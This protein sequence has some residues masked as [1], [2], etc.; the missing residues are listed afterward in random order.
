MNIY[1]FRDFLQVTAKTSICILHIA[2]RIRRDKETLFFFKRRLCYC[3]ISRFNYQW[4]RPTGDTLKK[5]A[6]TIV[7]HGWREKLLPYAPERRATRRLCT[8]RRNKGT[9]AR[10]SKLK[11]GRNVQ[12]LPSSD[13]YYYTCKY[14]YWW[15][16]FVSWGKAR[17]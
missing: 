11:I 12:F 14:M 2:S 10:R 5:N 6:L 16:V 13:I 9:G 1:N 8:G 3:F 4:I 7:P 15:T 17:T